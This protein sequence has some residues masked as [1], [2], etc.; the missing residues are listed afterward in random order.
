M[1]RFIKLRGVHADRDWDVFMNP[2]RIVYIEA[3]IVYAE[4]QGDSED[5][6][7]ICCGTGR[8]HTV[9]ESPQE[10]IDKVYAALHADNPLHRR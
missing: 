9:K 5:G 7:Y 6:S 3:R 10:V 2:E 8:V 4:E 1:K